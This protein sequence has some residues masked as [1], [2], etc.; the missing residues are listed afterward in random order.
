VAAPIPADLPVQWLRFADVKDEI[1]VAGN[2]EQSDDLVLV[3]PG[4]ARLP[5]SLELDYHADSRHSPSR[6]NH[7]SRPRRTIR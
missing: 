3:L 6:L 2:G 5:G 4:G 7:G 1:H